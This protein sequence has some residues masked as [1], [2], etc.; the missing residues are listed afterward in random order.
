MPSLSRFSFPPLLR[1]ETRLYW[2]CP[3]LSACRSH[4][5]PLICESLGPRASRFGC[6][7]GTSLIYFR[8]K[9]HAHKVYP[10]E[11][12]FHRTC[13]PLV[14]TSNTSHGLL[15]KAS[16]I[17]IPCNTDMAPTNISLGRDGLHLYDCLG[18]AALS[19]P[20]KRSPCKVG[21]CS[22]YVHKLPHGCGT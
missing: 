2:L 8:S 12:S 3:V 5:S 13:T 15:L 21:I 1:T 22:C 9:I 11:S 17:Q 7:R 6:S 14:L 10:F 18:H 20:W 16:H 4:T 19:Q